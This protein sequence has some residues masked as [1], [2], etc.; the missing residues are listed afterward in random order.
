MGAAGLTGILRA[1]KSLW[2]WGLIPGKCGFQAGFRLQG[3]ASPK[4]KKLQKGAAPALRCCWWSPNSD[5]AQNSLKNS[6]SVGRELLE[7]YFR[8]KFA[9]LS[10]PMI[11]MG[12]TIRKEDKKCKDKT[13]N[14]L[15]RTLNLIIRP[16]EAKSDKTGDETG[17]WLQFPPGIFSHYLLHFSL[18]NKN[19]RL[20]KR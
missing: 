10:I 1:W 9:F 19:E 18:G 17:P 11:L 16:W 13:T 15:R 20:I 2:S 12:K 14:G 6:S 7:F 4:N 8:G 5:P 3:S